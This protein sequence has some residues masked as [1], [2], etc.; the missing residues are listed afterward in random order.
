MERNN[1]LPS[2]CCHDFSINSED[3]LALAPSSTDLLVAQPAPALTESPTQPVVTQVDSVVEDQALGRDERENE[4]AIG[5][6][7]KGICSPTLTSILVLIHLSSR[8]GTQSSQPAAFVTTS[9]KSTSQKRTLFPAVSQN[10][11]LIMKK[12]PHLKSLFK[13]EMKSLHEDADD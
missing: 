6:W 3:C 10:S 4:T 7:C 9:A 12:D 13:L 2:R 11:L 1:W 5:I 8:N